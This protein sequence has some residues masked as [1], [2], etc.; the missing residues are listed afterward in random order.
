MDTK[1]QQASNYHDLSEL[2]KLRQQSKNGQDKEALRAAAKQFESVFMKMLLSS[3]RQASEVLESDS[4]FN[5]QSSKFYRDM[6]DQQLSMNLAETGSLGLADL[7]VQQLSHNDSGYRPAS[8]LRS[9]GNIAKKVSDVKSS[10]ASFPVDAA[11]NKQALFNSPG[12]FIEKLLPVAEDVAKEAGIDPMIMVAQAALETG[13]GSKVINKDDGASSH[14]LFGIKADHR[15]DGDTAKVQTTEYRE[16]VRLQTSAYFRAYDSVE[17][18]MKD[19]VGFLK[20]DPR[21]AEALN[22]GSDPEKYFESLQ[23][24]GYATDPNYANKIVSIMSGNNFAQQKSE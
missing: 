13:W 19:Y 22:N 18:S 8:V 2:D 17:E 24:A 1:L 3:M 12:E 7:I 16:G 4:P 14:N 11:A 23:A 6:H 20:S 21:Y 9:D 10:E 5:S 15:W